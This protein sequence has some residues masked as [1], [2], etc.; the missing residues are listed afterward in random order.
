MVSHG[1]ILHNELKIQQTFGVTEESVVVSWLPMYH[2]MGLISCLEALYSG[3][4]VILMSPLAFLQKPFRWLSAISRYRACFSGG[5]NFAYDLCAR[6]VTPDQKAKLDL[7]CWRGAFVGAEPVRHQ[8]LEQFSDCFGPSGFRHESFLPCYGLAE[9]TLMVS[10]SP[11][12]HVPV[13]YAV[14][15]DA[16]QSKRIISGSIENKDAQV[17]VGCGPGLPDQKTLIVD[18]E[19]CHECAADEEGE[20]WVSGPSVAQG[21]WNKPEETRRTFHAYLADAGGGPFLRTGD[22]GFVRDSELFITGRIKDQ[23]IVDGRNHHPQDV[24]LAA[25]Q[26]HPIIR[27]A[28]CAAFSADI[29]GKERLI[30]VAE[31]TRQWRP[32]MRSVV[33]DSMR[34]AVSEFCDVA[35]HQVVFLQ[36]SSLPRTSSGKVQRHA[37]RAGYL[38][39]T[40]TDG[41]EVH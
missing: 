3:C 15:K 39:R 19:T 7:S 40:L 26:S 1:N 25:E 22:L 30:V 9:A 17:M 34:E 5:P 18:P 13:T 20:I 6:K 38:A 14:Q 8:T 31:V 32:E 21:Y 29:E 27:P 2:D 33:V 35:I 36:R 41:E 10:C 4:R 23:I 16:L 11:K 28:G 12:S 37:C 24:E